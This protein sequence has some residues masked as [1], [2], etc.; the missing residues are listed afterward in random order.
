MAQK[1]NTFYYQ[2][3]YDSAFSQGYH[4]NPHYVSGSYLQNEILDFRYAFSS[5]LDVG[6]AKGKSVELFNRANKS[7]VG[8][9]VSEV[10][11]R[12]A[13]SLSRNV[14]QC[15]VVNMPFEDNSFEM[16]F[17][18]DVLEHLLAEDVDDAILE[19]ARVSSDYIAVQSQTSQAAFIGP[20]PKDDLPHRS[21]RSIGVWRRSFEK[22]GYKAEWRR[23]NMFVMSKP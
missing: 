23:G 21:I 16:V 17:C 22:L 14:L 12:E 4:K 13:V 7:V 19:M 3:Y 1:N 6:C 15:S 11:V 2:Q 8:I 5:V 10:A 18:S 20:F 9:D